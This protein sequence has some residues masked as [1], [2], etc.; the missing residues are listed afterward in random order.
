MLSFT[1]CG[2]LAAPWARTVGACAASA[3]PTAV[4]SAEAANRRWFM[5]QPFFLS[6]GETVGGS[7]HVSEGYPPIA[8]NL[9]LSGWR[10]VVYGWGRKEAQLRVKATSGQ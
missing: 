9:R 8:T 3:S 2:G 1:I 10:R 7:M 6:R 5:I 4:A